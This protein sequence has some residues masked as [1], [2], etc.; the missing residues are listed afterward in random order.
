MVVGMKLRSG[1][2]LMFFFSTGR[3]LLARDDQRIGHSAIQVDVV[4]EKRTVGLFYKVTLHATNTISVSQGSGPCICCP[5][6][7]KNVVA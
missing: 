5:Q 2:W 3:M 4:G 6:E 1:P 7:K